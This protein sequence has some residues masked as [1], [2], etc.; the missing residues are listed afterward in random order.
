MEANNQNNQNYYNYQNNQN[1]FNYINSVNSS[2]NTILEIYRIQHQILANN[3]IYNTPNPYT[4]NTTY[5]NRY[6]NDNSQYVPILNNTNM[7][8]NMN[9]NMNANMNTNMNTNNFYNQADLHN[10][11]D[12]EYDRNNEEY[13]DNDEELEPLSEEQ[14]S[15]TEQDNIFERQFREFQDNLINENLTEE[16]FCNIDNPINHECPITQETFRNYD[17]VGIINHCKHIFNYNSLIDWIK[18]HYVCPMCRHDIRGISGELMS[19]NEIINRIANFLSHSANENNNRSMILRLYRPSSRRT[20]TINQDNNQDNNQD[21]N[22]DNNQDNNQ[23][24]NI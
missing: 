9:A 17:R 14:P 11:I 19:F 23:D 4:N 10:D 5:T 8:T 13:D 20:N 12:N 3:N 22:P 21:D 24:D 1:Y 15:T 7:N 18:E 6:Y 16:L 2:M